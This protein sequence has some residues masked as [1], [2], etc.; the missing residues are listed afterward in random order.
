[1]N[2]QAFNRLKIITSV[3]AL[4]TAPAAFCAEQTSKPSLIIYSSGD[5]GMRSTNVGPKVVAALWSDGKIVWSESPMKGDQPYRQG[6]FSREK[7]DS[8]LA[9]LEN[10]GAYGDKA[11]ARA[12][13][14]PDSSY[15]TIAIEDGQRRLKLRSWHESFEQ[16]TNLVATA[17]G[18]TSLRGRKREDVLRQQP[19][20]YRR[21]RET[22]S[23]IREAV[24]TLIPNSGEPYDGD[25]PLPKR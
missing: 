10:K 3:I 14:G 22:W 13:F 19:E 24:A 16:S 15:T 23:E 8:L 17:G 7:L 2:N 4:L 5:R 12:W 21:F 25:I 1:M 9:S 11:L 6:R 18:I 20:E